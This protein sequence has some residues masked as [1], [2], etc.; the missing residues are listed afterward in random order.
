MLLALF[1]PTIF[2]KRI[3]TSVRNF[4]TDFNVFLTTYNLTPQPLE[5]IT[6]TIEEFKKYY[7]ESDDFQITVTEFYPDKAIK[8]IAVFMKDIP[9]YTGPTKSIRYGNHYTMVIHR[10]YPSQVGLIKVY[11]KENHWHPRFN[12]HSSSPCMTP[13]GEV[14]RLLMDMP[15]FLMYEPNRV[16]PQGSDNGVNH[17]AMDWY[18]STGMD[19]VHKQLLMSW[20]KKR[21][22]KYNKTVN[23]NT[24]LAKKKNGLVILD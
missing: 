12:G 13:T 6:E 8:Q 3:V 24:G 16:K 5:K 11:F 19:N 17:T 4:F 22:Q 23:E 21:E 20:M 1:P 9:S 7:W 18:R 15:F 2:N 14:D 10:N